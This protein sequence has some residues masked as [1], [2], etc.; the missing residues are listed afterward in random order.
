MSDANVSTEELR[1]FFIREFPQAT[2]TIEEI[3]SGYCRVRQ[4]VSDEHFRPGNTV[5]GPTMMLLADSATYGAVLSR[6]GIVPLAVTTSMSM[7]F[8][9]RPSPD[10]ALVGEARLLKLGKRLAVAEVKITSEGDEELVAHATLTYS[11]PP[12]SAE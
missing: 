1:E 11:I 3:D 5:S 4:A 7:N 10:A 6:I 8:L 12:Q 9:R 2:V